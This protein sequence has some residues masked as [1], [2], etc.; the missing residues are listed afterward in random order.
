KYLQSQNDDLGVQLTEIDSKRAEIASNLEYYANE[1]NKYQVQ[2]DD[3]QVEIDAKQVEINET[4]GRIDNKQVEINNKQ[5]EI[6]AKQL[7]IDE[8]Q[9]QIDA[10]HV[11]IEAKQE[12]IKDT[13]EDI[14]DLNEK[15]AERLIISQ[16]TMR[17]NKYLEILTGA[18][19]L[20]DFM[21]IANGLNSI[22]EFDNK[23]LQDMFKLKDKLNQQ[24]EELVVVEEEMKA[25]QS[26]MEVVRGQMQAVQ[27]EM[28]AQKSEL[29]GIQNE[30]AIQKQA[31]TNEQGN[32]IA[33]QYQMQ[34]IEDEILRQEAELQAQYAAIAANIE[35]KNAAMR[36]I[37]AAGLLQAIPVA[38]TAS[39]GWTNPVPNAIRSAGTWFYPG[40]GLHLGYDFAAPA[41]SPI[42]APANGVVINSVNGCAT[43]GALGNWCT[44]AG[45]AYGGGNQI[46]LLVVVNGSLY[47]VQMAHMMLDSPIPAGTIV[48]NGTQVGAVGS[49]GNSTG[50][51]CHV[52][53]FYLGDGSNFE[54][55]AQTWNGDC[56]FG[57]GWGYTGYN[58]RCEA[59]NGAPCRIAPETLFGY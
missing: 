26:E 41:G 19:S 54:N 29:E 23:T 33:M 57:T 50:P 8:V 53:I 10:K 18:S 3:K 40:G 46:Y 27:A 1:I 52:E 55:Y 38:A 16:S 25:I 28:V 47:G 17:I 6:D 43:Y 31:L 2:I 36:E 32:M 13:E 34:V 9:L 49:S 44:G 22:S 30:Q 39:G 20:E 14:D 45:G 58:S 11:E 59:G 48:S 5:V 42:Y 7:E 51:H 15:V 24:K 4:Q 35:A 21:R 12:E 37:A 56:A